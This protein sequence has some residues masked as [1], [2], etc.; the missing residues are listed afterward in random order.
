MR[1]LGQIAALCEVARPDVG[2]RDRDRPGAPRAARHRRAGRAGEGG[3]RRRAARR[4][5]RGR[6]DA[7]ARARAVP[8]PRRHRGPALRPRRRRVRRRLRGATTTT[9]TSRSTSGAASSSCASTSRPATRRTTPRRRCSPTTRSGCPL[10]ARPGGGRPDRVLALARGGNGASRRR[11]AHQ[12][13]LQRQPGLDGGRA[14]RISARARAAAAA[15]PCSET[16]PSWARTRPPSTERSG[17]PRPRNADVA[18]RG[19]ASSRAGTSAPASRTSAT[20]A[21]VE[22]AIGGARGRSSD[23]ATSCS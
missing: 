15:S 14:R 11:S 9:P 20:S 8:R 1:G 13:R 23:R 21:T 4:R 5:R 7:G 3:D 2:D 12:R 10:D 16:W 18:R 6:A 17:A 19:R 22:D